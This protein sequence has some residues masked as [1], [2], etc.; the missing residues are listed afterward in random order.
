[1]RGVSF[2]GFLPPFPVS[3]YLVDAMNA[4]YAA[5]DQSLSSVV[6]EELKK[7]GLSPDLLVDTQVFC[8]AF[9]ARVASSDTQGRTPAQWRRWSPACWIS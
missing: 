3:T 8:H 4:I 5:N 1:M 7:G 6:L 2:E 9:F